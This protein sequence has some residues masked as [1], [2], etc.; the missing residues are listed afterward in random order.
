[1]FVGF[2]KR[3]PSRFGRSSSTPHTTERHSPSV[4]SYAHSPSV[5]KCAQYRIG[6]SCPLGG[7]WR[8][9]HPICRS[10]A[11]V[12]PV[13]VLCDHRRTSTSE[14]MSFSFNVFTSSVSSLDNSV[15]MRGWY[16][17]KFRLRGAAVRAKFGTNRQKIQ[18][19]AKREHNF[20]ILENVCKP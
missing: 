19:R 5:R 10:L 14:D 15:W 11:S 7:F 3:A 13:Y 4:V 9:T 1:M 20:V 6:L 17:R 12:L 18:H 8:R 16:F 2:V